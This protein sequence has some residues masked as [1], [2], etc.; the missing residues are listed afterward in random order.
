[1]ATYFGSM[2][3]V[4]G[5]R[6]EKQ[7]IDPLLASWAGVHNG[8]QLYESAVI[9]VLEKIRSNRV[10][11]ILLAA[12]DR[13]RSRSTQYICIRPC[14][15]ELKNMKDGTGQPVA[16]ARTYPA[17]GPSAIIDYDPAQFPWYC[18]YAQMS[19]DDQSYTPDNVLFHELVHAY[20]C[21]TGT[22]RPQQLPTG[23]RSCM[24]D[25]TEELIA[26]MIAN[27]YMSVE[28]VSDT[29]LRGSHTIHPTSAGPGASK[30]REQKQ[31]QTCSCHLDR[32]GRNTWRF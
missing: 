12:I 28:G 30:L 8:A 19:N 3:I 4:E 2:I 25:N 20:R 32:C 5:G 16:D 29:R 6:R 23:Y 14:K 24:W 7:V 31:T 26:V 18:Q 10:G 13:A 21:A 17:F 11:A 1:M 22:L 9:A 27:T 15:A